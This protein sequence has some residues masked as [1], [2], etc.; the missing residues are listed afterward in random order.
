MK[1]IYYFDPRHINFLTT[2]F[3]DHSA[4]KAFSVPYL[5]VSS[6]RIRRRAFR[7]RSIGG[8]DIPLLLAPSYFHRAYVN[9]LTASIR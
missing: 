4:S 3:A 9:T 1:K 8:N 7:V 5:I 6:I 2:I